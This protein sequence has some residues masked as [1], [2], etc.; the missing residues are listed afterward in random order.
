[1]IDIGADVNYCSESDLS[2]SPIYVA[3]LSKEKEVVECLL[4]RNT[5]NRQQMKEA[6]ALARIFELDEIIG[7][8][9]KGLGLDNQRQFLNL[10]GLDL[11]EIKPCWIYPSLGLRSGVQHKRHMRNKS[12]EHVAVMIN[13]RNS[14]DNSLLLAYPLSDS[15]ITSSVTGSSSTVCPE[16]GIKNMMFAGGVA[17]LPVQTDVEKSSAI[18][19]EPLPPSRYRHRFTQG[20][21]RPPDLPTVLCSPLATVK[22]RSMPSMSVNSDCIQETSSPDNDVVNFLGSM[23]SEHVSERG[24][25]EVDYASDGESEVVRNPLRRH[26]ALS[27][28][29]A[30]HVPFNTLAKFR[31]VSTVNNPTSSITNLIDPVQEDGNDGEGACQP[32]LG[33]QLVH[34]AAQKTR[35]HR[36]VNSHSTSPF[37]SSDEQGLADGLS[38]SLSL[39][40][41]ESSNELKSLPRSDASKPGEDLVDGP[42]I[43]SP[44]IGIKTRSIKYLDISSNKLKGLDSLVEGS[45]RIVKC[46]KDLVTVDLKQNSLAELPSEI[47]EVTI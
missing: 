22:T 40:L 10:G 36:F 34:R 2:D 9:L 30:T 17:M 45:R 13:K 27:T 14:V 33:S 26:S 11:V 1:M 28:T 38:F 44:S 23:S 4:N 42:S 43:P 3:V 29:G 31:R 6:L 15:C 20:A 7:V 37:A 18:S 24:H 12:M 41:K 16:R 32:Y 8:L 21:S 46:L 39:T 19:K 47:M 35:D 25:D 5:S